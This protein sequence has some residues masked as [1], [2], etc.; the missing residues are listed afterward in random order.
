VHARAW[1]QAANPKAAAGP[2][3]IG[4]LARVPAWAASAS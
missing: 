4:P 2:L 1:E 3:A